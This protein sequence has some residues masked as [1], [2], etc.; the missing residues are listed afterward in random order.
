[1]SSTVNKNSK[2]IPIKTVCILKPVP[3]PLRRNQGFDNLFLSA[4]EYVKLENSI[5]LNRNIDFPSL[6]PSTPPS[7]KEIE[8]KKEE[9]KSVINTQELFGYMDSDSTHAKF[10]ETSNLIFNLEI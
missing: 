10:D 9:K 3:L 1:M 6:V 8:S 7:P 2:P 4:S 5:P